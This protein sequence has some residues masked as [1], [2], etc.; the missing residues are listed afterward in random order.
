M[1]PLASR[2]LAL[3][4]LLALLLA[5]QALV[6]GPLVAEWRTNEALVAQSQ[7][8]LHR[9]RAIAATRPALKR[10]MDAL[11]EAELAALYLEGASDALAAAALQEGV[12]ALVA[13]VAGELHSTQ[14][15]PATSEHG[16]RRIALRV[17]LGLDTAALQTLLHALETGRPL[18]F[19]DNLVLRARQGR[20]R[21]TDVE[22][23]DPVL[24]VAL[25]LYGYLRPER[26]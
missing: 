21:R 8:L 16:L 4:L 14:I 10:Q 26:P 25:D 1:P 19:L 11:Q 18:L 7:E 5:G 17:Q 9:Y 20:A 12:R 2:L 6:V 23:D 15:L 24:E 3:G 22:A 13:E